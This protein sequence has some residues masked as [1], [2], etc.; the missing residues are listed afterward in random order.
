M[1]FWSNSVNGKFYI[2]YSDLVNQDYIYDLV[3]DPNYTD[4]VIIRVWTNRCFY[5][6]ESVCDRNFEPVAFS[7]IYYLSNGV[8]YFHNGFDNYF[9][10]TNE[11]PFE[12]ITNDIY[13]RSDF[14]DILIIF[15][16]LFF[17]IIFIPYKLFA[18]FFGRWLKV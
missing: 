6:T 8:I 9:G 4:S 12:N 15:F 1:D 2:P 3:S 5:D 18:R 13:Y 17:F 14:P 7:D 11:I 10:S 16:F